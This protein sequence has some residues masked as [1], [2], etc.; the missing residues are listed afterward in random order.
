MGRVRTTAGGVRIFSLIDF[1][2]QSKE[3][4][5]EL[6]FHG[7]TMRLPPAL[8]LQE[9]RLH[10]TRLG[11]SLL[12]EQLMPHARALL[13]ERSALLPLPLTLEARI[14]ALEL[15]SDLPE[16]KPAPASTAPGG[17]AGKRP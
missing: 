17:R 16:R 9:D 11:M 10:A 3:Q 7:D 5:H 14:D 13:P 12:V 15:K 2:K 1:V 4:G 8:L 6:S